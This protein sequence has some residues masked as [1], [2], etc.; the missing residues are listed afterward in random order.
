MSSPLRAPKA[1]ALAAASLLLFP[2]CSRHL[3][4][5]PT[6][7]GQFQTPRVLGPGEKSLSVSGGVESGLLYVG[8]WGASG[9]GRMGL[10]E[11]LEAALDAS[12]LRIL[13]PGGEGGL[14][15]IDPGVYSANFRLKGNPAGAERWFAW[16]GGL[17]AGLSEIAVFGTFDLGVTVG[18]ENR[19][20]IP[21][22]GVDGTV[23]VPFWSKTVDLSES[24]PYP[25]LERSP[26]TAGLLTFAGLK[27][28][29]GSADRPASK[30]PALLAEGHAS[31]FK[32]GDFTPGFLGG[33]AALE[34]PIGP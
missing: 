30:R 3:M 1:A 4:T 6:R 17:G 29:L 9:Q 26:P 20:L 10:G 28:P 5:P 25:E 27:I 13:R 23:N 8:A 22:A 33:R 12:F 32:T 11:G 2:A 21:Y 31:L 7:T 34:F 15:D 18:Y 16:H 24:E 14:E 19:W